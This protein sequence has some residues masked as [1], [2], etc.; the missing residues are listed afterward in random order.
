[1]LRKKKPKQ[2]KFKLSD[3]QKIKFKLSDK[4]GTGGMGDVYLGYIKTENEKRKKGSFSRPATIKKRCAIKRVVNEPVNQQEADNFSL[5]DPTNYIG[6]TVINEQIYIVMNVLEGDKLETLIENDTL[7]QL[8]FENKFCIALDLIQKVKEIHEKGY[9]HRD[10]KPSNCMVKDGRL[11]IFDWGS[12]VLNNSLINTNDGITKGYCPPNIL[13]GDYCLLQESFEKAYV[14]AGNELPKD[15]KEDMKLKKKDRR[16][17]A[18]AYVKWRSDLR[19]VPYTQADEIHSLCIM[20]GEIFGFTK[21]GN[22]A[23]RYSEFKNAELFDQKLLA[24]QPMTILKD[25][26]TLMAEYNPDIHPS[27]EIYKQIIDVLYLGTDWDPTKRPA[28][29]AIHRFFNRVSKYTMDGEETSS[30]SPVLFSPVESHKKE[31]H[32]KKEPAVLK[33]SRKKTVL[34]EQQLALTHEDHKSFRTRSQTTLTKA[35]GVSKHSPRG[36]ERRAEGGHSKRRYSS[37]RSKKLLFDTITKPV[38][39]KESPRIWKEEGSLTLFQP[40]DQTKSNSLRS[41]QTEKENLGMSLS[42]NSKEKDS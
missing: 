34:L 36:V 23:E 32:E 14:A 16:P 8:P 39:P 11:T 31:D 24:D 2:T 38:T 13:I 30:H 19:I 12:A 20:M 26:K 25:R 10:L 40:S 28:A 6:T 18:E 1:M 21:L 9:V 22:L 27:E 5:L 3:G 33:K 42:K 35:S 29:D 17:A 37:H 15:W 4:L 41:V 7:V